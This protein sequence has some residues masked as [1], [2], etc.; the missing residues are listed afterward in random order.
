MLLNRGKIKMTLSKNIENALNKQINEEIFSSYLYLSMSADFENK[1]LKGF[2]NWMKVQASEEMTHAMKLYNFVLERGCK[3]ELESIKKPQTNWKSPLQAFS[4]ALNHE[5][6]ITN[7]I[8]NLVNTAQKEKDHATSNML[9][10][11]VDEQV[12]EEANADEILSKLKLIKDNTSSLFMLDK[13]LQARVFV[14]E[15]IKKE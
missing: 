1:N 11:F 10:W 7:C 3:I 8:N 5:Q 9:Q 12:E 4:D 13:E 15:T 2:A 14:D 6:F